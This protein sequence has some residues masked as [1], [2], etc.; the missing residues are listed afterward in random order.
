[1]PQPTNK[2]KH[3]KPPKKTAIHLN[4]KFK[5]QTHPWDALA[6]K[7]K[8]KYIETPKTTQQEPPG[9]ISQIRITTEEPAP[10]QEEDS[11]LGL[12]DGPEGPD[13]GFFPCPFC[14]C[15]FTHKKDLDFHVKK[16]CDR[17]I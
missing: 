1:M 3:A 17:I 11:S 8:A 9:Q 14:T 13:E 7:T 15:W 10:E 16:W 2:N 12:F 4:L 6:E 5:K